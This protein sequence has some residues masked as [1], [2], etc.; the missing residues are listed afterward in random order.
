MIQFKIPGPPVGKQRP[1]VTRHGTYTPEK[2]ANY[3]RL[4]RDIYKINRFPKLEGYLSMSVSAYYP[5]PKR[6][7]KVKKE[8][9][10]KGILLPDKKPDVD[11]VLKCIC[12]ALN[13]IAYDDDKQIISMFITKYYSKDPYVYVRLDEVHGEDMSC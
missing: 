7:S 11:N 4:I 12:D 6:T 9:M 1:R 10:L 5:I 3:E 2:T 13:K 8:K